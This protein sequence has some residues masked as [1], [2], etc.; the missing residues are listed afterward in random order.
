MKKEKRLAL[1]VAEV[2]EGG[3][4]VLIPSFALGR[5]Q[6][7]ILILKK[8]QETGNIP[9]FPVITDGLVNAICGVYE[10]LPPHL[11][12]KLYNYVLNSRQP[13]LS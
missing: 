6:E 11:S 7:I 8:M 13:Y 10:S 1:A 5:A 9:K 12:A 4:S 2:I 3:G